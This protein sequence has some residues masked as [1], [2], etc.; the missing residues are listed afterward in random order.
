[1]ILHTERLTL[2]EFVE[3]DWRSVLAYQRDPRYLRYYE[4]DDRTESDARAFV[5]RFLDQQAEV[6]RIKVQLAITLDGVV[7]GNVG[8]RRQSEAARVADLGYELAPERWGRGYATEAARAMLD[9]GFREL[10]LHRVWAHCLAEN[11]ASARVLEKLGMRGEG[12]LRRHEQ[13][14]GRWWDVLHFGIL[15]EEWEAAGAPRPPR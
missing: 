6:P 14:K 2:R 12:R 5:Q 9:W 10:D 1:M 7:V 8:L 3:S 11:V 15:R 4:G 13:L